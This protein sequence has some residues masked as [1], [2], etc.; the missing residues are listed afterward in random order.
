MDVDMMPVLNASS[1]LPHACPREH[2]FYV[3][4]TSRR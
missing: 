3:P 2:P 1:D 4:G